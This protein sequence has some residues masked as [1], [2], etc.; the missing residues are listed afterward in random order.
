[1][2][3]LFL[4]TGAGVPAKIRNVSAIAL[5]LLEERNAVWLF[6]CGEATQHQ[7]IHTS[8]KPRK[9]EKIFISHLHGDHIFGLPGLLGSRSFQGGTTEL[10]VYGPKGI[11]EFIQSALKVSNT[12]LKYPL[13][14]KEIDEGTVFEDDQFI[15]ESLLLDH[16]VPSYGFRIQ[17]KDKSGTLQASQLIADGVPPGPIYQRLKNG[18]L[19]TLD[20]GRIIDG[21]DYVGPTQKGRVIAI[22]G[23]TRPCN[24][25]VT[26][27]RDADLLIHEATFSADSEEM[28]WTY[29]HST[30]V[31][32]AKLAKEA[33]V[34]SLCLTHISS[35]YGKG[36][37]KQLA[38]EA[39]AV[40]PATKIANDFL[41][42]KIP[43]HKYEEE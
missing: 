41:E 20:D 26:L 31:Q 9:I 11:R 28:A 40:F 43:P 29:Y 35:R 3:V 27:A 5:M 6:D 24:N 4:G 38:R 19:V 25:T 34:A 14:I 22:M 39:K 33:N 7:I 42:I 16:G 10:I 23:D 8:L 30:T 15:V 36:D 17:E 13:L 32:T 18:E 2:E 37:W 12:H 21:K 1:M